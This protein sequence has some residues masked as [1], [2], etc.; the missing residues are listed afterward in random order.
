MNQDQCIDYA[1]QNPASLADLAGSP[2]GT[3]SVSSTGAC[4][5]LPARA[6]LSATYPGSSAVGTVTLQT[7]GCISRAPEF[8]LVIAYSGTFTISTNVGTLSG[9]AGGQ[10]DNVIVESPFNPQASPV[11]AGLTLMATSGTGLFRGTTGTLVVSLQFPTLG[12]FGFVAEVS[13]PA[14]LLLHTDPGRPR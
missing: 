7:E 3:V 4:G 13:G 6:P 11:T 1:I 10:I 5:D 9:T 2:T 12:C 8:P 14:T